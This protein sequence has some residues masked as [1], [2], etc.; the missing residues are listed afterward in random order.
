MASI[1]M[2]LVQNSAHRRGLLKQFCVEAV[3]SSFLRKAYSR[4]NSPPYAIQRADT[5]TKDINF[6]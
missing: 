5:V 3:S 6:N 4:L 1:R 2:G